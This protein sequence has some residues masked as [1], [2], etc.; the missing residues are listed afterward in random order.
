MMPRGL[1]LSF[2]V[3]DGLMLFYWAAALVAVGLYWLPQVMR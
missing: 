2:A 1:R 3:V